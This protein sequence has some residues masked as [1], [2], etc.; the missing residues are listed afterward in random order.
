MVGIIVAE[1]DVL[2]IA[3]R[4]RDAEEEA[5]ETAAVFVKDQWARQM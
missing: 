3:L 1:L 2:L 5:D 4:G